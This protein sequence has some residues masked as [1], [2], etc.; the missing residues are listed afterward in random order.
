VELV[1]PVQEEHGSL[2]DELV[3]VVALLQP[4]Q[5]PLD[6]IAYKDFLKGDGVIFGDVEKPGSYRGW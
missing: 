4:V 3:A 6:A 2:E 1:G 5:Q